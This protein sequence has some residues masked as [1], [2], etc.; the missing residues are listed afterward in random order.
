MQDFIGLD[1]YSKDIPS[2]AILCLALVEEKQTPT[3]K[4]SK[5]RSFLPLPRLHRTRTRTLAS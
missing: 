3:G 1:L 5:V 2:A 4:K